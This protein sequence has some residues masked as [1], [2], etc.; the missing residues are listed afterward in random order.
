MRLTPRRHNIIAGPT[1][2][3]RA[4]KYKCHVSE[5]GSS[6]E[7][8][9]ARQRAKRSVWSSTPW[10]PPQWMAGTRGALPQYEDAMW[11]EEDGGDYEAWRGRE[12]DEATTS[13]TI[14]QGGGKLADK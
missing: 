6:W 5:Q 3:A 10:V 1:K 8:P 2:R 9:S 4:P 11:Q 12:G 14:A 7:S 13:E